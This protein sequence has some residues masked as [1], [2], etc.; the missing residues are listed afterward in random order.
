MTARQLTEQGMD[1]IFET[2]PGFETLNILF[3]LNKFRTF[4]G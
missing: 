1:E 3:L 2:F 4:S